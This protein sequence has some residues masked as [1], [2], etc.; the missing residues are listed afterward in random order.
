MDGKV[1]LVTGAG[2]AI[3]RA[4]AVRFAAAGASVVV[5]DIETTTGEATCKEILASG[6][7]A[8]FVKAD[9]SAAADI[10]NLIDATVEKFGRLDYACNNAGFDGPVGPFLDISERAFEKVLAI[11]AK[12]TFLCMQAEI[13]QMLKNEGGAIVNIASV[14]GLLGMPKLA[15]YSAAKHA[16]NGLTKTAALEYAKRGIRINSVCPGG[17]DTPMLA[18]LGQ[19]K[20]KSGKTAIDTLAAAHPLGRIGTP[21]E[22]A[23]TVVFLCSPEASFIT[24]MNLPVDGGYTSI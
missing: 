15:A 22:I 13:R 8:I 7:K 16:V 2:G 24:G 5:S 18:K 12:G 14:A 1:A 23:A 11:N 17:I 20:D 3:G 19:Y 10:G 6:A 9:I 21:D 4:T